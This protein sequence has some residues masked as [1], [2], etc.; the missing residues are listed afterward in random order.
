MNVLHL[1]S[2]GETGGSKNHLLSFIEKCKNEGVY[3]GVF[4]EGLL[5]E[6]A[7][8]RNI[9]VVVFNQKSRYDFSILQRIKKEI[10]EK[11][12][13]IVHTHGPRANLF[14]LFLR[15][16][17]KFTWVTTIHSDPEKD[18]IK[19]GVKGKV[20]TAINMHVL[21]KIDHFFAV[22]NR[23]KE[24]LVRFGIKSEKITTIYNGIDFDI[25][26]T[27]TISR[28]QIGLSDEDFVITMVARLHPIKGHIIAFE[29]IHKLVSSGKNVKLLLIG[30]GPLEDELKKVVQKLQ[31]TD[32]IL[33]YGFQEDVHSF[34]SLSD[35]KLLASYS[36]S[37]PL[38]ILEAARAY[39]PVISTDVGGVKDLISDPSL[40]WIINIKNVE[41]LKVAIEEAIILKQSDKLQQ[42]ATNLN[43]KASE[44]Y[45]VDQLV[46]TILKKYR[47]L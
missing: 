44:K 35:V 36:E 4:Q 5:A 47:T 43:K 10:I 33:F 38:V 24:M 25:E 14:T 12:I 1:I 17:I 34:L 30:N 41:E 37:F 9:P 20:F 26:L 23:F 15:R 8:K 27:T 31:L 6:E 13:N 3:L 29:A 45:S 7:R 16:M 42:I 46:D 2:G 21:K 40:G 32:N 18:F 19:G 28:K 22:S 39:T 11:K